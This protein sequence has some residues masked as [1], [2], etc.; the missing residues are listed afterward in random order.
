MV[1]LVFLKKPYVLKRFHGGNLGE[2]E[3]AGD[4][5]LT[6]SCVRR[7]KVILRCFR[8]LS[9]IDIWRLLFKDILEKTW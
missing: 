1:S 4:I 9:E 8:I 5:T 2:E 3:M 6:A 7:C